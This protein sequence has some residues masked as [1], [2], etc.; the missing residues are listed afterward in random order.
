VR[1]FPLRKED[2]E[3]QIATDD[4]VRDYLAGIKDLI[5]FGR[6]TYTDTFGIAH[7]SDYCQA[8]Q[9]FPPNRMVSSSGHAR[10]ANYNQDDGL[11]LEPTNMLA[12]RA[13]VISP[14]NCVEPPKD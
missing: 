9:Q 8:F 7:W 1:Q 3:Q 5:A 4:D 13:P 10:C 14:V 12:D 6:I 2:G 11:K